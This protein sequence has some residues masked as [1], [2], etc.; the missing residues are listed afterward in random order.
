LPR[1]VRI[2]SSHAYGID[3]YGVRGFGSAMPE[4]MFS[5]A[6]FALHAIPAGCRQV[7][8]ALFFYV[9]VVLLQAAH[10]KS[11]EVVLV[12]ETFNGGGEGGD[13]RGDGDAGHDGLGAHLDLHAECAT[14]C[15]S[16][17]NM[18]AYFRFPRFAAFISGESVMSTPGNT[19]QGERCDRRTC[20]SGHNRAEDVSVT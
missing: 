10:F 5:V 15:S 8:V 20:S 3:A 14:T 17:E 1:H 4:N 6:A 19:P 16:N 12:H 13:G 18:R 2:T 11:S 9:P 7:A